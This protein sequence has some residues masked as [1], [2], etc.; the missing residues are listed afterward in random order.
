MDTTRLGTVRE[1]VNIQVL[2]DLDG[3][4]HYDE[5]IDPTMLVIS[6]N[7]WET[8]FNFLNNMKNLLVDNFCSI[9]WLF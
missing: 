9:K 1:P 6:E 5:W 7:M 8:G 3:R 2:E 4:T